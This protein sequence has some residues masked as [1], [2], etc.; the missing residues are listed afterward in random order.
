M[1]E[2]THCVTIFIKLYK[3]KEHNML[4][5]APTILSGIKPIVA[6]SAKP[7][8]C[9]TNVL[10]SDMNSLEEKKCKSTTAGI[11]TEVKRLLQNLSDFKASKLNRV[12]CGGVLQESVPL[13]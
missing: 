10:L 9:T 2:C 12:E 8:I 7:Y 3:H 5:E 4:V 11:L 6:M 1:E 13:P